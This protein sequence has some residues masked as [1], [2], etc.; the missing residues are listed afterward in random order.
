MATTSY[1]TP[2]TM[3]MTAGMGSQP[4][5]TTGLQAGVV[6][7]MNLPLSRATPIQVTETTPNLEEIQGFP[8]AG[9]GLDGTHFHQDPVTG[10]MYV[11]SEEFHQRIPQILSNRRSMSSGI[12]NVSIIDNEMNRNTVSSISTTKPISISFI[13][14]KPAPEQ[15]TLSINNIP[16][17]NNNLARGS[18][19]SSLFGVDSNSLNMNDSVSD[20]FIFNEF[21]A[22]IVDYSTTLVSTGQYFEQIYLKPV[23]KFNNFSLIGVN[24]YISP[25][26]STPVNNFSRFELLN[27]FSIG[28]LNYYIPINKFYNM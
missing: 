24:E 6:R 14:L 19:I 1:G 5:T 16:V 28:G 15:P 18:S 13:D 11:M 25:K 17:I 21:P 3:G 2:M 4:M 12:Q 7:N 8:V 26:Q 27:N 23:N 22:S 20:L 9:R 10:Q